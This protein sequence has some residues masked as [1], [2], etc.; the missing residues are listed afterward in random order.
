M[1][2]SFLIFELQSKGLLA[3]H[4]NTF[5]TGMV[6]LSNIY[7][8]ITDDDAVWYFDPSENKGYVQMRDVNNTKKRL[9]AFVRFQYK[10]LNAPRTFVSDVKSIRDNAVLYVVFEREARE[11]FII[12]LL[13]VSIT[14][15]KNITRI[16]DS[17]RKKI[18]RK[19]MLECKIDCDVNSN[20]NA[21]TQV[22][23]ER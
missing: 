13:R 8:K 12:S 21:R 7:D 10:I 20:T 18:T 17:Y 2:T 23:P 14:S 15:Q 5:A 1:R 22:R 19:S 3:A 16:A 4:W 6:P 11:F 9:N